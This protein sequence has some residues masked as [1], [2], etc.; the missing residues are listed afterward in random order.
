MWQQRATR[1]WPRALAASFGLV[2][3]ALPSWAGAIEFRSGEDVVVAAGTVLDDDLYVA[4]TTVTIDGTV[5]GDV[6]AAGRTITVNGTIDGDLIA[7]GQTVTIDGTVTDD[8]RITGAALR[9][10]PGATVADDLLA[11]GASLEASSG[12][13]VG[14]TLT[15]GGQQALLAGSVAEDVNFGGGALEVQGSVGG[16]LVVGVGDSG[17]QGFPTSSFPGMPALPSVSPGLTLGSGATVAGNLEYTA[18]SEIEVPA[19]AVSGE[20]TYTP[21]D[22]QTPTAR[23][24]FRPSSL[25]RRYVALAIVGIVLMLLQPAFI[26]RAAERLEARPWTG[27]GVGALTLVGFPLAIMLLLGVIILVA[28]LLGFLTLGNLG[29]AVVVIGGALVVSLGALFF[30]VLTYLT[31]IVVALLGGRLLLTRLSPGSGDNPL[32]PLLL[33]LLL[34]VVLT[35]IPVLGFWVTLLIVLFGLGALWLAWMN[36]S[37]PAPAST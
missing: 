18:R 28:I 32:G 23:R 12:S 2:C 33:G 20:V 1:W 15:F 10:G 17:P 27:L 26:R 29:G 21:L 13:T 35:G 9:L 5:R 30:L 34:V 31:Q 22:L 24:S 36:R 11:S 14:G 6:I 3:L 19:A 16:D 7:A 37:S 25:A 8:V 4:A